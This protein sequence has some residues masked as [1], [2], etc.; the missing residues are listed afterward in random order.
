MH[1]AVLPTVLYTIA[2]STPSLPSGGPLRRLINR[3]V[4]DL[5]P[6]SQDSVDYVMRNNI[7]WVLK[8]ES[9]RNSVKGSSRH[10]FSGSMQE[11]NEGG[12]GGGT[13]S[14]VVTTKTVRFD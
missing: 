9:W 3:S 1:N 14:R 12:A 11:G 13:N 6:L 5:I 2:P 7:L 4:C 8:D 10:Y